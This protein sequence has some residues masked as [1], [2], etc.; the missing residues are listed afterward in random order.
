MRLRDF[1]VLTFDCY[2]TLIDWETGIWQALSPLL[3][4][5]NVVVGREQTLERYAALESELERGPYL[6]YKQV[7]RKVLEG[8]GAR[9]GF[10][11]TAPELSVYPVAPLDRTQVGYT[12]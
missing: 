3:A 12:A 1:K 9:L 11:P 5:H 4:D 7:L 8:L 2:G 6:E 10:A